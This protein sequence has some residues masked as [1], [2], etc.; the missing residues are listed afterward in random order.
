MGNKDK[1]CCNESAEA[2]NNADAHE[3]SAEVAAEA[4][5][6]SCHHELNECQPAHADGPVLGDE[7]VSPPATAGGG[8]DFLE[9]ESE[10]HRQQEGESIEAIPGDAVAEGPETEECDSIASDLAA[11]L[12]DIQAAIE[13]L[14]SFFQL[15]IYH[16]QEKDSIIQKL[17]QELQCYKEDFHK[18]IIKPILVDLIYYRNDLLNLVRHCRREEEISPEKLLSLMEGCAED[19]GYILEKYDVEIYTVESEF[20]TPIKQKVVEVVE[21][22][23]SQLDKKVCQ[24]LAQGYC[25]NETILRP[26]TVTV[27]KYTPPADAGAES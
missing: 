11:K 8:E 19:I 23:D 22:Q 6:T 12:G 24:R 20:F 10:N 9:E 4:E 1:C 3:F 14:Q 21:T 15:K 27:Y 5:N 18:S 2:S 7:P 26:E 13:S 25:I 16:D 17:H